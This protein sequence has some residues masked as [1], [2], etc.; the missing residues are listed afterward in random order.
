MIY[1]FKKESHLSGDAQAVGEH[2]AELE[3]NGPLTPRAVVDANRE[4]GALLHGYFEWDDSVAAELYRE[5][6][7]GY[8]I[9][10][11]EVVVQGAEPTRAFVSVTAKGGDRSYMNVEAALSHSDTRQEVL[12]RALAEL[13]AFEKKYGTL[14]ELAGVLEEIRKVA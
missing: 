3:R 1:Q 8:I 7:A 13:R 14:A 4:E 12:D 6:Q 10:M 9:R 2:L 5:S 11:V